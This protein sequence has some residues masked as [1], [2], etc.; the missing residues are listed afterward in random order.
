MR[1]FAAGVV[2]A[3]LLALFIAAV[4]RTSEKRTEG[5]ETV[6]VLHVT[7]ECPS[8]GEC[9]THAQMA[10]HYEAPSAEAESNVLKLPSRHA[11]SQRS[12]MEWNSR[13]DSGL[14]TRHVINTELRPGRVLKL[15]Y[16]SRPYTKGTTIHGVSE[17][18]NKKGHFS[19]GVL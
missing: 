9:A 12:Y 7:V 8:Q 19:V 13:T 5:Q 17:A 11:V 2:L 1:K 6:T 3:A 18:H 4:T 14:R 15:P 10:G 16:E